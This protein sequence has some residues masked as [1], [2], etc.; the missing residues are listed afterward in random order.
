MSIL[1]NG[2]VPCRYLCNFHVDFRI[3]KCHLSNLKK[4]PCHVTDIFSHVVRLQDDV[5]F[6]KCQCRPVGF[7]GRGPQ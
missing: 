2:N 5:D 6:K 7:K 3:A 4:G 1:R